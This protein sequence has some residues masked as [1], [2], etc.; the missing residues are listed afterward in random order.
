M[1][2]KTA[3]IIGFILFCIPVFA[4]IV[5]EPTS[6]NL[7]KVKKGE[8]IKRSFEIYNP[9]AAD[10]QINKIYGDCSCISIEPYKKTVPPYGTTE[11]GIIFDS[12]QESSNNFIKTVYISLPAGEEKLEIRGQII[13]APPDSGKKLVKQVAAEQWPVIKEHNQ[14]K[15]GSPVYIAFFYSS[16]CHK[17]VEVKKILERLKKTMPD[18][19]LSEFDTAEKENRVLLEAMSI[20][21][22]IQD[23]VSIAPPILFLAGSNGERCLPGGSITSEKIIDSIGAISSGRK[24]KDIIP[25]WTRAEGL[26]NKAETRIKSRFENFKILPVL[27][28]GLVDGINPCAFGVLIF[29]ITYTTMSLKR[30]KKETLFI[31]LNFAFGVFAAYLLMGLGLIKFINLIKNYYFIA[32]TFYLFVGIF[33]IFLAALSFIDFYSVLRIRH[34][35]PVKILLKLPFGFFTK[36]FQIV[37][38]FAKF[39]HFIIIS[40]AIGFLVSLLEFFCTGQIYFPTL[41]YIVSI[42]ELRLRSITMLLI[43]CLAFIIPLLSVFALFFLGMRSEKIENFNKQHLSTVKFL[44]GAIF[45]CFGIFILLTIK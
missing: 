40:F 19:S 33:A 14:T 26:K 41:V 22:K 44:N 20:L 29:I 43:Y 16:K 37:E 28:A 36:I 3:F 11:V 13:P 35:E 42:P 39:K 21:Y 9:S 30:S 17:C 8:I 34:H 38:K 32:K 5:L 1:I 12:N 6:L 7:Y 4:G 31:G 10:L 27:I 24:V 2:K 45:L 25:P 18:M 15:T 23:N